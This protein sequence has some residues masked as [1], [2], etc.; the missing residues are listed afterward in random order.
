[1]KRG[2]DFPVTNGCAATSRNAPHIP[3]E[4]A[5]SL[6]E[7][8]VV[9][10][11]LTLLMTMVVPAISSIQQS[12]Q[13]NKSSALLRDNL[14]LA[15]QLAITQN[16]SIF[17]SL[18]QVADESGQKRFNTLLLSRLRADG[19]MQ[20]ISKPVRFPPGFSIS[21]DSKWS[22]VMTLAET[23]V[24]LLA[25]SVPCRQIRFKAS[26]STD[27]PVSSDWFLTIYHDPGSSGPSHNFVTLVLDPITGRVF[28]YQ[29]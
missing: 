27:L 20:S 10:A 23:N 5:F 4:A 17:A 2:A 24:P 8:L 1:M 21:T 29:P 15:R 13:L 25:S 22:S 6:V 26:G 7:L 12:Y 18:C 19:S 16:T 9:M 3:K 28:S 11:I 14:L